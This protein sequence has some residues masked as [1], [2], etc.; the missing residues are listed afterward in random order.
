MDPKLEKLKELLKIAN[1]GLSRDDFTKA[2]KALTGVV[3]RIEEQLVKK[4]EA[5]VNSMRDGRDGKNGVDGQHGK[6]P[7]TKDLLEIIKPLIPDVE[8]GETPSDE[9]ISELIDNRLA[10]LPHETAE[11][12]RNKL[13]LL[14][15]KERLSVKAIDGILELLQTE[16]TKNNQGRNVGGHGAL[17]TLSDVSLAGIIAGQSIQWDGHKWIAYTPAGSSGTPVWAE[18]LATQG[19]GTSFTLAHTPIAGS[20][21]L[22]RGGAYQSIANGDYSITG[23]TITLA[24]AIIANEALVADYSY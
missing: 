18:N 4:I 24:F 22:F 23:A 20:V 15:G 19:L 8:D 5:K 13:E 3:L 17:Y 12:I 21:R 2:F 10:I 11:D 7:T 14:E 16:V 6:T 9:Q 1:D